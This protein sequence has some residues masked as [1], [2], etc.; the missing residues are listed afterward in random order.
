MT[1]SIRQLLAIILVGAVLCGPGVLA[2]VLACSTPTPTPPGTPTPTPT[3]TSTPTSTPTPTPT[4]TATP[5]PTPAPLAA[6]Y[7]SITGN[8]SGA[9][10]QFSPWKSIS[11]AQTILTGAAPGTAVYFHG[12]E[13]WSGAN[14]GELL[15]T[16]THGTAAHPIVIGSYGTGRPIFDEGGAHAHCI[17]A[18]T[19]SA[20]A[21]ANV[22]IDNIECEHYTTGGIVFHTTGSTSSAAG[23][24]GIVVSNAYIH[25]GGGGC[26][27]T[28]GLCTTPSESGSYSDNAQLEFYDNSPCFNPTTAAGACAPDNVQFINDVV[29]NSGGHNT[30]RVHGD[31]GAGIID[32]LTV[33]PCCSHNCID[34]KDV[35]NATAP[36]IRRH[37]IL[38]LGSSL[39]CPV[40][41]D[42]GLYTENGENPHE[43]LLDYDNVPYD[44]GAANLGVQVCG[45]TADITGGQNPTGCH[46]GACNTVVKEYNLTI[47]SAASGHTQL[48][49]GPL[50][51]STAICGSTSID[52]QN[53]IIDGGRVSKATFGSATFTENYNDCGGAQGTGGGCSGTHDLTNVNPQYV[54]AN[55]NPPY[56][57]SPPD[58]TIGNSLLIGSGNSTLGTSNSNYGAMPGIA[59]T[60]TPNPTGTPTPTPTSTGT[61]T[62]TP[63]PAPTTI[64]SL[65]GSASG[66]SGADTNNADFGRNV[67]ATNGSRDGYSLCCG[68]LL[69]DAQAAS[70][71]IVTMKSSVETGSNGSANATANNYFNSEAS[72][73]PSGYLNELNASNG[74][75]A[76]Y[77]GSSWQAEADRIDGACPFANPTTGE[78]LQWAANKWG[79]NPIE[80]YA[81]SDIEGDWDQAAIGD[82]GR[83]SGLMQ[84]ADR[85][86]GHAWPGFSG[87]GANLARE[88]T[89]FNADYYAARLW[90]VFNNG[91]AASLTGECSNVLDIGG[92]IQSWFDGGATCGDGGNY[93][94]LWD[95]AIAGSAGH[96]SWESRFFGNTVVPGAW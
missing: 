63:S 69:T 57:V 41:G 48:V 7:F 81:D 40:L 13:F 52:L 2:W 8:D 56:N 54:A 28:N 51:D 30:V 22:T 11:K 76:A 34:V 5:T 31:M 64:A 67:T 70:H 42:A 74:F 32:G 20:G 45:C 55:L 50:C 16:N 44:V 14:A 62:P 29:R 85:G 90:S 10:T 59:S 66:I 23:M 79:I 25:N 38:D 80:M 95:A 77:V 84:V 88:S 73:D 93:L 87:S 96:R 82:A 60:P 12:G 21:V 92:A 24:P 39:G 58:F 19:T 27:A 46:S 9:G 91:T 49:Y 36:F 86:S 78:V 61:A 17:Y 53:A 94:S 75:Y 68:P 65:T 1:Q 33:G 89:C 18:N 47:Y 83:S 15:L 3:P 71:V 35:G 4:G 26:Y 6:N 72:N 37:N 43:N